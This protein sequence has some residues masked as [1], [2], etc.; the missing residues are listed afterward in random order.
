MFSPGSPPLSEANDRS[1][2]CILQDMRDTTR[3]D[4]LPFAATYTYQNVKITRMKYIQRHSCQHFPSIRITSKPHIHA[5]SLPMPRRPLLSPP[6]MWQLIQISSRPQQL[7]TRR[8]PSNK[9]HTRCAHVLAVRSH[10][11]FLIPVTY[12]VKTGHEVL[13]ADQISPLGDTRVHVCGCDW[14]H[15]D[16]AC[17][18]VWRG[19]SVH[20]GVLKQHF[21]CDF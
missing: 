21:L 14:I 19:E 11:K 15:V 7:D 9:T 3:C 5:K 17:M 10:T 16:M 4:Q 20:G 12:L 1:Y 8:K 18:S 13:S 2:V 6:K